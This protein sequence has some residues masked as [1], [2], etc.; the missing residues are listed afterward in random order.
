MWGGGEGRGGEGR[1]GSVDVMEENVWSLSLSA[2]TKITPAADIHAFGLCMLE[3]RT[4][5]VAVM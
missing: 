1:G 3:V 4:C 2:A 5:H